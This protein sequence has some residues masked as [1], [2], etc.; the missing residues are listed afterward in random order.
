MAQQ[1]TERVVVAGLIYEPGQQVPDGHK[2][3]LR[4]PGC[5]KKVA[6]KKAAAKKAAA[7]DE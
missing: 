1:C 4:A 5:F 7:D 6:E 2:A 3:A